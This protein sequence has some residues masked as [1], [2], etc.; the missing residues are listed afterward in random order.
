MALRRSW[1]VSQRAICSLVTLEVPNMTRNPLIVRYST[2][3]LEQMQHRSLSNWA[4]AD[5]MTEEEIEAAIASDPD[6]AGMVVD[7][8]QAT[9]VRPSAEDKAK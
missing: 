3:E 9:V 1:S 6:E 2:A 7:W 5:A 4:A 8:T